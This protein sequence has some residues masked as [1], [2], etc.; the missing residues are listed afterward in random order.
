MNIIN[1]INLNKCCRS[2]KLNMNRKKDK[3]AICRTC[4]NRG[5][6]EIFGN[7]G[8]SLQLEEKINSYLPITVRS[9]TNLLYYYNFIKC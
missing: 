9:N 3:W 4:G 6:V 8:I 2:N 7:D 1:I 5:D